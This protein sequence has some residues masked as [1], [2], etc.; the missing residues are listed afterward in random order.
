M[1]KVNIIN[2]EENKHNDENKPLSMLGKKRKPSSSLKEINEEK[3][4]NN[5][6]NNNINI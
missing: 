4:K 6:I 1:T 2:N 3:N 5:K